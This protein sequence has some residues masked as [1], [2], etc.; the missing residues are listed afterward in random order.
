MKGKHHIKLIACLGSLFLAFVVMT[1]CSRS[2]AQT[3]EPGAAPPA[4]AAS[5]G[6]PSSMTTMLP[7]ASATAAAPLAVQVNGEGI[8][9]SEYQAEL[10]RYR[11]AIGKDLSPEEVKRVQTDLVDQVLLAQGAQENGFQPDPAALRT[12]IEQLAAKM[13][14]AEALASWMAA[15]HYTEASFRQVMER[16]L[17]AA[18]MRDRIAA[19]TPQA[20]EQIHARQ[21]LVY[22]AAQAN[23]IYTQLQ[24]GKDFATLAKEISPLTL[25]DLGWFPKGYLIDQDLEKAVFALEPGQYTAV[26]QSPAG[27]HIL[28]MIERDAQRQLPPEMLRLLQGQALQR[29]LQQQHSQANIQVLAP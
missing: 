10:E 14:G 11:S 5:Q 17:Q 7:A 21:I 22:N 3:S 15:N 26:I 16:S 27:Y 29:W 19:Q 24:A 18:W 23:E 1:G 8:L 13:G 28:Q 25:G 9:L 12:H 20:A 2:G 4:P 6:G